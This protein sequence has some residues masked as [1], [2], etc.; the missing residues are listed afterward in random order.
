MA[1]VASKRRS[2][3]LRILLPLP[4]KR[5]RSCRRGGP[6]QDEQVMRDIRQSQLL[7]ANYRYIEIREIYIK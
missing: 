2:S 6:S 7:V 1:E 3:R 4:S 5:G